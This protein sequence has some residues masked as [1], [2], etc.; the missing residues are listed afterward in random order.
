MVGTDYPTIHSEAP[1]FTREHVYTGVFHPYPCLPFFVKL[2]E[3]NIKREG[4]ME[5]Q[6]F[7]MQ[8]RPERVTDSLF[9]LTNPWRDRFLAFVAERALGNNW[10]GQLP[11]K[12]EV[13]GWL[14]KES[15]R[16]A[17]TLLLDSWQGNTN[18]IGGG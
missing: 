1:M 14:G 11:T 15:L 17:V 6:I 13:I 8:S 3:I 18:L 12:K 2:V 9:S 10:D 16:Q 7:G 5:N 4:A